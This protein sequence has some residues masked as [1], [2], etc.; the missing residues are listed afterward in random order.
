MITE[1]L[2]KEHITKISNKCVCVG[3]GGG[4]GGANCEMVLKCKPQP[5]LNKTDK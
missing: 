3:G 2:I 1:L 5:A 4:G